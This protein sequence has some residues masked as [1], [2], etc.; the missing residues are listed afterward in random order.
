LQQNAATEIVAADDALRSS[1][2]AYRAASVLVE[3][4]TV[5]ENAALAAYKSGLGTLTASI[6]A[7][8]A[9][10]VARLA[11]APAHGTALIAA[12]TLAFSTGR[13]SSSDPVALRQ[14]PFDRSPSR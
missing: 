9:L 11:Q 1:L 10:L 7:Q 14:R 12:A 3:A 8:R 4:S 6:E 5:T 2:A 13:L